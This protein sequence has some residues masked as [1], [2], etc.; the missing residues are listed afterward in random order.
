VTAGR[1]DVRLSQRL[2]DALKEP[3]AD[4]WARYRG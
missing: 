2:G 3:F 1:G 4:I